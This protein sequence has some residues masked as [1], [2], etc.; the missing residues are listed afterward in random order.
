[1]DKVGEEYHKRFSDEHLNSGTRFS[2]GCIVVTLLRMSLAL[3]A[4]FRHEG[5]SGQFHF[6]P[7]ECVLLLD[8]AIVRGAAF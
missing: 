7:D 3:V 5:T 1:M 2:Q 4:Y 8:R 6:K